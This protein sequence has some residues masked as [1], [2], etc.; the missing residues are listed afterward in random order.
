MG[1]VCCSREVLVRSV[2]PRLVLGRAGHCVVFAAHT[3]LFFCHLACEL[4][5]WNGFGVVLPV[6]HL[7]VAV[8]GE[9]LDS[10]ILAV[11]LLFFLF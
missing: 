9:I 11:A 7:A 2:R 1:A 6:G 10:S 8:F 5:V 3:A 4:R